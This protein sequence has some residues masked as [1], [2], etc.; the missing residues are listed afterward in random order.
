MKIACTAIMFIAFG[1]LAS[2]STHTT[3]T[4]KKDGA[5]TQQADGSKLQGQIA[6]Y[7]SR[8]QE[9]LDERQK[10][11]ALSHLPKAA[12]LTPGTTFPSTQPASES[13]T[14]SATQAAASSTHADPSATSANA[15]AQSAATAPAATR[16]A[17]IQDLLPLLHERVQAQPQNLSLAM[18]LK[19]LDEALSPIPSAATP[20]TL[21]VTPMSQDERLMTDLATVLRTVP[22][23]ST[24]NMATRSAPLIELAKLYASEGDLKIP[25]M[26]LASRV[27]SFGVYQPMEPR[28][29]SGRRTP[30][31][32]YFEVSN[33]VNV[34]AD[35]GFT[36]RLAYQD[37]LLTSDGMLVWRSNPEQ[38]VDVCRNA[39][40]DFYMVKRITFPEALP[41][42]QYVLKITVTDQASNKIATASMNVSVGQ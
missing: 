12:E 17:S 36:T 20:T 35:N 39:R 6:A 10:G 21:P 14:Q 3:E 31:L 7:T 41:V 38:T 23:Q 42:G 19:L 25:I 28:L 22:T 8:I 1:M 11:A 16:P 34:K 32:L 26:T 13:T 27:D 30:T 2:C 40:H 33:F 24:Q 29:P 18:S 15:S 9:G 37:T 5:T 4:G